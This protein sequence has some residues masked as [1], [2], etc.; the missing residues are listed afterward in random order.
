M[1][2]VLIIAV[3]LQIISSAVE[4]KIQANSFSA[5]ENKGIS[6]FRGDVQMK[7]Q[8]D[9]LN[10]TE[11]TIYTNKKNKPTKFVAIGN[12]VFVLETKDGSKYK[13]SANKVIYMPMI[14]EYRF[15]DNVHLQQIDKRKEILGDE[16]VLSIDNGKAYAKGMKKEP[17]IMI[18]DIDD[19][20]E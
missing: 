14:K 20:K 13:G 2:Y 10:A 19:K 7:K 11:V 6:I 18:F 17:V 16:V 3:F 12:V 8:N 4:L 1:K 15:Y 9:E 5:D